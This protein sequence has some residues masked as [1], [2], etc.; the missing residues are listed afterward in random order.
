MSVALPSFVDQRNNNSCLG[1]W[2][3]TASKSL[4][5]ELMLK[6][7]QKKKQ[8]LCKKR[9]VGVFVCWTVVIQYVIFSVNPTNCPACIFGV[10]D[11]Q[12]FW[13]A[14]SGCGWLKFCMKAHVGSMCN[15]C[16]LS[17]GNLSI[18]TKVCAKLTVA[19]LLAAHRRTCFKSKYSSFL[20][21]WIK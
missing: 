7:T 5:G 2:G 4:T 16:K 11:D 15:L 17:Y 12:M 3:N 18:N 10:F 21:Q 14:R 8:N 9:N 19:S 1:S 20:T 6:P 13:I